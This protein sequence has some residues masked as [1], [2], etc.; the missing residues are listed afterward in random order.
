MQNER[1]TLPS[2]LLSLTGRLLF[3]HSNQTI[4]IV[5]KRSTS[6]IST[7]IHIIEELFF[8]PEVDKPEIIDWRVFPCFSQLKFQ[9]IIGRT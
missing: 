7:C 8:Y 5:V 2:T 6:K 3:N 1:F 9:G 4:E